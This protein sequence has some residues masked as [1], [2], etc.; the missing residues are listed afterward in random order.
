[1]S[2]QRA[3]QF[4][5]GTVA[6]AFLLFF[7]VILSEIKIQIATEI[8]I[9]ALFAISFNLLLGYAGLLAFGHA[10]LFG[11]GAYTTALILNHFFN[12]PL[13]VTLLI[14]GLA[15]FVTSIII[16]CF[17]LRSRGVYFALISFAFQMFLFAVALKWRSLTKGDDG[18]GI[19][20]PA[21]HL[22]G[23]GTLSLMN[24]NNLYYL[25][26]FLVVLGITACYL[27]LKTPLGNAV[28]CMRENDTRAAF[29]GYN[30]FLTK[31]A[32]F[33]A[34][35][36]LA[37]LAGGLFA[38]FHE[39]VATNCIDASMFF[40]IVLMTVIGGTGHFLGPVLGATFFLVFQDWISSLTKHWWLLM[41]MVFIL[42][43]LYLEGGLINLF[44]L[45][46]I[47]FWFYR[48]NR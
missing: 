10:A 44:N 13:L 4:G 9:F 21:V 7:P 11:V 45:E 8:L 6:A 12:I 32:V 43:V 40:N 36:F 16:G 41:G 27:F 25:I 22:P 24:I 3:F 15:G 42:V 29:L 35:G 20:R 1:M 28:V 31:L 34:S 46:K 17:A 23:L 39:F 2:R 37:G 38:V 19:L 33:S 14:A 26:L 30:V 5:L 47:R 48:K 18:M